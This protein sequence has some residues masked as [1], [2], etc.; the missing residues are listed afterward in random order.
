MV[1]SLT[2]GIH[3][4]VGWGVNKLWYNILTPPL[5][6]SI[7]LCQVFNFLIA[8]TWGNCNSVSWLKAGS[9]VFSGV[10]DGGWGSIYFLV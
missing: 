6:L 5:I 4:C 2:L 1:E 7:P 10:L 9:K 3:L 8:I